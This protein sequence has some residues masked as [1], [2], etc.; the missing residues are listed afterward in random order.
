VFAPNVKTI[1]D[2]YITL[3]NG[4]VAAETLCDDE[5]DIGLGDHT[6]NMSAMPELVSD[7]V[8]SPGGPFSALTPSMWPQ[9]ILHRLSNPV[10]L[11]CTVSVCISLFSFVVCENFVVTLQ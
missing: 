1:T 5:D 2:V 9:D 3:W 7:F 4:S 10:C 8:P 6:D 11:L